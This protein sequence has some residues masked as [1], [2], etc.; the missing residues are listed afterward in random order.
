MKKQKILIFLLGFLIGLFGINSYIK[1]K[2]ISQDNIETD[3]M[4]NI[5][6]LKNTEVEA[7]SIK[8]KKTMGD[9]EVII[10]TYENQGE[11]TLGSSIYKISKNK[12]F[13][14]DSIRLLGYI[15]ESA[16]DSV[17]VRSDDNSNNSKRIIYGINENN[18]TQNIS[19]GVDGEIFNLKGEGKYFILDV[20]KS[21]KQLQFENQFKNK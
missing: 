17:V 14:R 18:K 10:F 6:E 2:E 21:K 8:G 20:P 12:N 5:K 11:K 7:I 19:I 1:N 15:G 4:K 13:K 16:N 9:K 3:I